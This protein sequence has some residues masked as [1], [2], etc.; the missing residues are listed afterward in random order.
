MTRFACGTCRGEY[1]DTQPDGTLYFH[2]C[3]PVRGP[4][5]FLPAD[6]PD[7][8]AGDIRERF[9]KRDE[10]LV[11]GPS[12]DAEGRWHDERPR[13]RSEGLGRTE[14]QQGRA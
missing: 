2:A 4:R 13:P 3:P 7:F 1:S 9:D 11:G 8:Y 14:L 12:F 6:H 10:N 5:A